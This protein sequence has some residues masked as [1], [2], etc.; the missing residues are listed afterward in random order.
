VEFTFPKLRAETFDHSSGTPPSRS[1]PGKQGHASIATA[2][3]MV[4]G[5]FMLED[6]LVPEDF[7]C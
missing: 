4:L 1:S 3:H 7:P 2:I 6:F 5:R